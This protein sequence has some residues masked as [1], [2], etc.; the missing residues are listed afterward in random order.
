MRA[1]ATRSEDCN[2]GEFMSGFLDDIALFNR[3]LSASEVARVQAGDFAP[4]GVAADACS[5]LRAPPANG[6]VGSCGAVLPAGQTCAFTC[7]EGFQLIGQPSD[8]AGG[9]LAITQKC[10]R[11]AE[12]YGDGDAC[13]V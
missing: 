12:Q 10:I 7:N 9:Q 4:F 11:K 13:L 5:P 2:G 3:A 6:G 1:L 8:C